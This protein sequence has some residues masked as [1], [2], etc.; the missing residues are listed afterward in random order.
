MGRLFVSIHVSV[1]QGAEGD[2][3]VN[4]DHLKELVVMPWLP[5]VCITLTIIFKLIEK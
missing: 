5:S 3:A 2:V 1:W 4:S